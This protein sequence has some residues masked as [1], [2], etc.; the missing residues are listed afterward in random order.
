MV[1]A[2]NAL[3]ACLVVAAAAPALANGTFVANTS[4]TSHGGIV[5]LE[6][7]KIRLRSETLRIKVGKPPAYSAHASYTLDNPGEPVT[8]LYGVPVLATEGEDSEARQARKIRIRVGGRQYR[9]TM[10]KK[11]VAGDLLDRVVRTD[12]PAESGPPGS[13]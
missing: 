4:H 1:L 9:C 2:R 13:P 10:P 6:Q 5:P 3:V 11:A 8:L 12:V 7:V